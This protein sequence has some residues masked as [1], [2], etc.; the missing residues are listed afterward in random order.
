MAAVLIIAAG[1]FGFFSGVVAMALGCSL[2]TA[3]LIWI[4]TGISTTTVGIICMIIPRAFNLRTS[5]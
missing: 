4:G 5:S 1:A 3:L 2:L